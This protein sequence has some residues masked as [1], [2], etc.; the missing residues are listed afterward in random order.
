MTLNVNTA[1]ELYRH[2]FPSD[3]WAFMSVKT[4]TI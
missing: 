4:Y 2:I 3:R 1:T